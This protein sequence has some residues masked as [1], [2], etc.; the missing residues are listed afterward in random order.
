MKIYLKTYHRLQSYNLET[1]NIEV[2]TGA[3]VDKFV[4]FEHDKNIF[5]PI[6][7][8]IVNMIVVFGITCALKVQYYHG[9]M[10]VNPSK[11]GLFIRFL[12]RNEYSDG[13]TAVDFMQKLKSILEHSHK[14]FIFKEPRNAV[15]DY[16]RINYDLQDSACRNNALA[17]LTTR[18][19]SVPN[20]IADL[21]WSPKSSERFIYAVHF[22]NFDI[23]FRATNVMN[24]EI[25]E[26]KFGLYY[27]QATS[28]IDPFANIPN[29]YALVS[30]IVGY[31]VR[32]GVSPELKTKEDAERVI[33]YLKSMY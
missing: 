26:T 22:R 12:F 27:I 24:F 9:C 30:S 19:S 11:S 8:E 5:A 15:N 16:Y 20:N 2:H 4:E 33:K 7:Q 23:W 3:D 21:F 10:H 18:I 13:L 28:G 29:K 32:K 6:T 31:P 1:G 17:Y 25:K 14:Y